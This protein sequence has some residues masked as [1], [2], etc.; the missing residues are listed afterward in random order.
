MR[1]AT[2][3]HT[4]WL[5]LAQEYSVQ[6]F[7]LHRPELGAI[8]D[9]NTGDL[10]DWIRRRLIVDHLWRA[11]DVQHRLRTLRKQELVAFRLVP[12]GRWL[13]VGHPHGLLCCYDLH[14]EDLLCA[15]LIRPSEDAKGF[16]QDLHGLDIDIDQDAAGLEFKI[17]RCGI[18][19]QEKI[20]S[21]LQLIHTLFRSRSPDRIP[22]VACLASQIERWQVIDG[23]ATC[24]R[25]GL[26]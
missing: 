3:A 13:L 6:H 17:V 25:S 16:Q 18:G 20:R 9:L 8:T 22:A 21:N 2:E 12:G 23:R 15:Q 26:L 7:H 11:K 10:R 1:E 24:F 14:S 19:E 4:I 5:T